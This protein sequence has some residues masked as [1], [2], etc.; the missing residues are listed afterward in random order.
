MYIYKRTYYVYVHV[1]FTHTDAC[2]HGAYWRKL[3]VFV[4]EYI[5]LIS[6]TL[7]NNHRLHL[8]FYPLQLPPNP[9][10]PM[11]QLRASRGMISNLP[12]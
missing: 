9:R 11:Q 8:A 3:H 5:T 6:M 10:D 2:T 7:R 1:I 12:W 4:R